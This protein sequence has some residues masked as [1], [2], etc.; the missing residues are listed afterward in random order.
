MSILC[1]KNVISKACTCLKNYKK[2]SSEAQDGEETDNLKF[3]NIQVL[4]LS[5]TNEFLPQGNYKNFENYD[6]FKVFMSRP[7]VKIYLEE[8]FFPNKKMKNFQYQKIKG[9][10]EQIKPDLLELFKRQGIKLKIPTEPYVIKSYHYTLEGDPT[11]MEELD[12]YT[13][14]FF[15]E[16]WLYGRSFM[17]KSTIKHVTFLHNID[18]HT[19]EYSQERTGCPDY[20]NTN[21]LILAV[22]EN[23]FAYIRIVLHHELFHYIDYVVNEIYVD[24]EWKSFNQPGFTYGNGGDSEREWIKLEKGVMGF[25]NHYSTTAVEEDKAEIYQYLMGDPDEALNNRDLIVQKKAKRIQKFMNDFDTEGMGKSENNFWSNLID[26]R[27]KFPYK[28]SVFQGNIVCQKAKV[29]NKK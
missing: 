2:L 23:N 28:E 17:K 10:Y 16:W 26:F 29:S 3:R 1:I 7:L 5:T 13:P 21:G 18:F 12:I 24:E 19:E 20:M 14:I 8:I 9:I 15:M 27:N 22:N 25:I 4:Q 11:D 6:L